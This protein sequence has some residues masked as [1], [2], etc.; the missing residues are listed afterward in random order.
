MTSS[1]ALTTDLNAIVIA[2]VMNWQK[3]ANGNELISHVV[4]ILC[5]LL[6]LMV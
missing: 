1:H 2:Y 5:E 3:H 4:N 6:V